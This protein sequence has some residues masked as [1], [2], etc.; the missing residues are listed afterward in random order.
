MQ[1]G[2]CYDE[3]HRLQLKKEAAAADAAKALELLPSDKERNGS[4]MLK[5]KGILEDLRKADG[6][7]GSIML[8]LASEDYSD[9]DAILDDA[10]RAVT[11]AL[12]A[13][14]A[15]P[16]HSDADEAAAFYAANRRF[17]AAEK[18]LIEKHRAKADALVAAAAAKRARAA[19]ARSFVEDEAVLAWFRD[20]SL[21]R[22]GTAPAAEEGAPQRA[23]SN[24]Y[25][26]TMMLIRPNET[27]RD[28]D[29]RCGPR[30]PTRADAAR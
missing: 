21:P 10:H 13:W 14:R 29:A 3:V 2:E 26:G 15:A 8:A 12:A 9:T 27:M 1:L 7:E 22:P 6:L 11:D 4:A 18:R 19:G 23:D 17:E 30:P 24:C 16:S 5:L 28:F 20:P 25:D